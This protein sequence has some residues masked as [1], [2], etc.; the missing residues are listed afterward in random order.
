ME[1]HFYTAE[2]NSYVLRAK[3][4]TEIFKQVVAMGKIK[5]R[6]IHNY[7]KSESRFDIYVVDKM[8]YTPLIKVPSQDPGHWGFRLVW[9]GYV[10]DEEAGGHKEIFRIW[11]D[12]LGRYYYSREKCKEKRL[13]FSDPITQYDALKKAKEFCKLNKIEFR[14]WNVEKITRK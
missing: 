11:R 12:E 10:Y 7:G 2:K 14:C 4:L 3:N 5:E 6:K 1:V 13:D 8:W 9:S